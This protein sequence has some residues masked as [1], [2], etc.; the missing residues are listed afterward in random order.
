MISAT[1]G[2]EKPGFSSRMKEYSKIVYRDRYLLLMLLPIIVYYILFHYMPMTGIVIA[3]KEFIPGHGIYYGEWVGLKWIN[4]FLQSAYAF[5]LI[6]NTVLISAYS[7][8]FGFPVPILFAVCVCEISHMKTRRILQ[9]VTYLPHFISTVVLVGMLKNF[10]AVDNGVVNV[11][12]RALGGAE[13]QFFQEPDWFRTLYVGS[14]IWQGFGWNSIIYI[15][16]ISGIDPELYEAADI[17]GISRAGK[18]RHITIPMILPTIVL[19][20]IMRMGNLMSVG[21]EKVFLMYNS[22]VYETADVIS[23]YVYRKGITDSEFSFASAVGVFNSV[24]NFAFVYAA[25]KVSKMTT[26]SSLW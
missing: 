12:I 8:L 22:A 19:L 20:F 9:T 13:I 18:V 26:D 16:S 4:Q 21:F 25:N 5:R 1:R 15:S 2:G 7:I 17:D 23:T 24:V 10:F 14:G 11:I 6:R 3:F